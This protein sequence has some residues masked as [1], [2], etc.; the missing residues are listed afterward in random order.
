MVSCGL[1][2]AASISTQRWVYY[3]HRNL[4][5]RTLPA[6]LYFHRVLLHVWTCAHAVCVY[7]HRSLGLCVDTLVCVYVAAES[8]RAFPVAFC[9][10]KQS[11]HLDGPLFRA[12]VP[13]TCL[14]GARE[15]H[16]PTNIC[17][18][19]ESLALPHTQ[20]EGWHAGVP[21]QTCRKGTPR[22][23]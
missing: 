22:R 8:A 10:I 11:G 23:G 16:L 17:S 21:T 18:H 6:I 3:F 9:S 5:G 4:S 13:A 19:C 7:A 20:E 14:S 12:E 15:G 2:A 1:Q